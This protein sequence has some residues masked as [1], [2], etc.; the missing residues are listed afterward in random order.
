MDS[1]QEGTRTFSAYLV[2]LMCIALLLAARLVYVSLANPSRFPITTVKIEA[3]Y[4]H[5]SR[6]T[7]ESILSPYLK[8]SFFSV[9]RG[10]LEKRFYTLEWVES[11]QISREWPDTLK[12][13]IIEKEPI[14]VWNDAYVASD[15][16]LFEQGNAKEA[17]FNGPY[18]TGPPERAH[19]V[20]QTYEKL[21][22]LLREYGLSASSLSLQENQS[23]E[24]TLTNG[25]RLKLGNRDLEA[26]LK[27]FCRAYP[28][29]FGDK[30]EL[31]LGVDLRYPHGMAAEWKQAMGKP[32]K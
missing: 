10:K 25:V 8:E 4:A 23:W 22:K 15:Y 20:L 30:P 26:R 7:I 9:P 3:S 27:R 12:V 13:K 32:G 19:E 11:A 28:A 29:V 24:L 5:V 17:Y 16:T 1:T 21:S 31:L 6:R 18:L 2:C 14:A